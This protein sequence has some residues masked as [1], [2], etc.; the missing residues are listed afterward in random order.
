MDAALAI[1]VAT[2]TAA[3]ILLCRHRWAHRCAECT[4]RHRTTHAPGRHRAGRLALPAAKISAGPPVPPASVDPDIT[5][6]MF[7]ARPNPHPKPRALPA[8]PGR[9]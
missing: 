8:T 7:P 4:W 9:P 1:A 5:S 3:V 2:Y 6:P